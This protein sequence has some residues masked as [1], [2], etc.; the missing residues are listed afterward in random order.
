MVTIFLL[1]SVFFTFG[2]ERKSAQS[3][4]GD[5]LSA[6]VFITGVIAG[7]PTYEL[8]AEGALEF[9]LAHP[10]VNIKIYEAGTNQAEWETQLAEMVSG[11]EYDVVIGS[12]PSLPEMCA[13]VAK[14]FPNQKFI[15]TDAQYDGH[16]QIRTYLY[17]Q[18]EQSLFLGYLAGLITTSSMPH[19][20]S[21]KRIGFIAA[22]EYPLLTKQMIPG[23]LEG[24]RLVDPQIELD[25]RIVGSWGDP[26]RTAELASAMMDSGVD[27]LTAIAGGSAQ[28][29]IKTA[30]ER[31]AYIVWY[32]NNVYNLA[33]GVIAGC[34][35]ME[36]KKLVME[37]FEDVLAGRMIY[38]ISQTLGVKEGYLGFLSE[39]SGYRD[40]LP[41]NIRERFDSFMDDLRSG[42]I[43]FSVPP[44]N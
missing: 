25:R 6:L 37:I 32:N 39:D 21:Q 4:T 40:S 8:M 43:S 2:C 24:A 16:P 3:R 36:Q 33:P 14:M 26:N 7:S 12:N 27:V 13:N 34:G 23:F 38:G 28:G 10:N 19:A 35:I 11:G 15:I 20:N 29:M 30:V 18:Y 5:N 22:Q 1:L 41:A 31:G 44:L 9:A 42:R 17:S